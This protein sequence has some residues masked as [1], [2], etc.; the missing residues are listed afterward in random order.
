MLREYSKDQTL[1]V[2]KPL[3]SLGADVNAANDH[4]IAAL[5]GAGYGGANKAVQILVDR[6]AKLDALGKGEDYGFGVSSV[7]MTPPNWAERVPIGM[8]S[9]IYHT[10]T[11]ELMSRLMQER[12]IP[13]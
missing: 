8:S 7:R 4:G 10:D 1:E 9:A 13:Q 11:V 5:H 6:G 2:I 12:G 3:L